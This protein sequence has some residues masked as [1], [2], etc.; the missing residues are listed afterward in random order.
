MATFHV[1]KRFTAFFSAMLFAT[2][3]FA[4][5]ETKVTTPHSLWLQKQPGFFRF[6]YDNVSMPQNIADMGLL[7]INYFADF[8][9]Y[10]Y[11]G[12]SGYGSITG[13]Q[14]GLFCFRG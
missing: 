12:I 2:S 9:P 14:G 10:L 4:A 1:R 3:S 5:T 6:S 11:G 7:G 8:T 13:T